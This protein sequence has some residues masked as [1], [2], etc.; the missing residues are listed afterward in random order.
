LTRNV[1]PIGTD[2]APEPR[3]HY[4][5]ATRYGGL[6]FVSN[7]LPLLPGQDFQMPSGIEAQ[8]AQVIR[9][10]KAIL[11]AAG[12]DLADVVSATIYVT[13]IADWRS[14]NAVYAESFGDHRPAR[15]VAVSPSLHL[16]ARV[17]MQAVAAAPQ[18]R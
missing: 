17:A 10:I 1:E 3:G 9:N 6:I 18:P 14:A 8:M 16:G 7:Q 11:G 2:E 12:A 4:A 15:T 13:D 5:Q